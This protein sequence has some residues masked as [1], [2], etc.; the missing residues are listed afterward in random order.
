MQTQ[1]YR[2]FIESIASEATKKTYAY[3]LEQFCRHFK[4]DDCVTLLALHPSLAEAQIIEYIIHL[5]DKGNAYG[6][7]NVSLAAILHFYLMNDIN[8]NRKKI[9]RFLGKQSVKREKGKAYTKE[10]ITNILRVC[11]ERMK[12]LILLLASSGVRIGAIP[13]MKLKHLTSTTA[14]TGIV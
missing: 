10:Q 11:D 14:N 9:S 3:S 13:E 2:Y 8:L 6:S 4:I 1:Q 12:A 5:K 7:I